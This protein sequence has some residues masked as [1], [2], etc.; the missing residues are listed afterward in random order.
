MTGS[1]Q[2]KAACIGCDPPNMMWPDEYDTAAVNRAKAVCARCN[3]QSACLLDALQETEPVRLG[4]HPR[5]ARHLRTARAT[6]TL[7]AVGG[8]RVKPT[9]TRITV[10]ALVRAPA[11]LNRR[12]QRAEC[13]RLAAV[14]ADAIRDHDSLADVLEA[15]ATVLPEEL[16]R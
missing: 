13:E 5:W 15:S 2:E 10:T 9:E 14:V 16:H 12:T 7:P 3:V 11:F 1:W 4:R 6:Q 8:T